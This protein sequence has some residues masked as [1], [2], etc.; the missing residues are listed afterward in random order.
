MKL[1]VNSELCQALQCQAMGCQRH[2]DIQAG[3]GKDL[4]ARLPFQIVEE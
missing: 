3:Q 1:G 4:P 2:G